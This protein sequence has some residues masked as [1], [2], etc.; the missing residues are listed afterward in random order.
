MIESARRNKYVKEKQEK[1]RSKFLH[2]LLSHKFLSQFWKIGAEPLKEV[3]IDNGNLKELK[4]T[5]LNLF[6]P[7][8][9]KKLKGT[10]GNS[11]ELKGT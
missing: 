8:E 5:H 1:E 4:G 7:V 3:K 11:M 9:L 6:E 10:Q 2:S